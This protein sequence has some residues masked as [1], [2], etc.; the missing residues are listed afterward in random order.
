ME[1]VDRPQPGTVAAALGAVGTHA[2]LAKWA[3]IPLEKAAQDADFWRALIEN[4]LIPA[5]LI[6][7]TLSHKLV[8][9]A[10]NL[11]IITG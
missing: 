1:K 10:A 6:A 9:R 11:A 4:H 7:L 8:R 3:D 5:E 2:S